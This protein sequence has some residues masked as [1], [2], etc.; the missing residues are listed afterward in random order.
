MKR[1]L[2]LL[3]LSVS[4]IASARDD[5]PSFNL[6]SLQAQASREVS[7]DLML[8]VL[9]V[10]MEDRDPAKLADSVNRAVQEALASAKEFKSVKVQSGTYRTYPVYDKNNFSHWRAR[11]ELRLESRDFA[12]ATKLIGKLQGALQLAGMEFKVA[13]DSRRKVENELITE[14]IAA[15]NQRAEIVRTSLKAG[16]YKLKEMNIVTS[17]PGMHQAFAASSAMR[18][19]EAFAAPA[20]EAGSSEVSVNVSGTI[21]LE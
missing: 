18:T 4:A 8:A 13:P 2:L 5:A 19:A 16:S 1:A 6:V 17:A 7:N 20:V 14:A 12:A 10:E 11:H 9:A 15:F 21:K 3:L